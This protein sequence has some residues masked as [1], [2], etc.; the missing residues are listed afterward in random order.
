MGGATLL[1]IATLGLLLAAPA[2]AQPDGAR[3]YAR[4]C[5][6][7]HGALGE[8]DGPTARWLDPPPRDLAAGSYRWRS[9]PSGSPPTSED[10]LRTIDEGVPGTSMPAWRDR[11]APTTRR[12][13][14]AYLR[15]AFPEGFD[16]EA[17]EPPVPIP[18]APDP[19]PAAIERGRKVYEENGCGDCHGARGHGDGPSAATLRDDLDRPISPGDF[20]R[21]FK[22]GEAPEAIYR[23]LM[24]GLDGTPMPSFADTI[25]PADRW[26][27]VHFVRSLRAQPDIY[28]YLFA[29]LEEQR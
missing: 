18:K 24:T 10:L 15:T 20:A 23:S 12:A 4:Y 6:T 2:L 3:A 11:L 5:A 1:P 27:L 7:C 9:T 16:P 25:A 13:L 26:P 19:S 29:P 8:G 22:V 17:E 21:P 14:V 28:D